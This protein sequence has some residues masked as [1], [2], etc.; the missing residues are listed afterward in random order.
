MLMNNLYYVQKYVTE[1]CNYNKEWSDLKYIDSYALKMYSIFIYTIN[2]QY[3]H[4]NSFKI[5]L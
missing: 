1:D 3:L 4:K 5:Y 2:L